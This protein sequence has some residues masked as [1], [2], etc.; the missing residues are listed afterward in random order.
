MGACHSKGNATYS[1]KRN[2]DNPGLPRSAFSQLKQMS[3]EGKMP[4]SIVGNPDMQAKALIAIDR[5]YP[6][7]QTN[8]KISNQYDKNNNVVGY[9]ITHGS[10]LT[11]AHFPKG[12]ENNNEVRSGALKYALYNISAR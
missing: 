6:A 5:L 3:R 10:S 11:I 7:A 2:A 8:H 1:T 4:T 12:H 9:R